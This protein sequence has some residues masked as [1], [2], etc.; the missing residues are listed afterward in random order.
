MSTPLAV[1]HRPAEKFE[2][3]NPRATVTLNAL[4]VGLEALGFRV[5]HVVQPTVEECDLA[6]MFGVYKSRFP[7]TYCRQQIIDGQRLSGGD[8]LI[9][10]RGWIHRDDHYSLGFDDIGGRGRYADPPMLRDAQRGILYAAPRGNGL[11]WIA[12]R[13][14]DIRVTGSHLVIG[15][16]P[17]DTSCQHADLQ[18][19]LDSSVD[20]LKSR[21]VDDV[22]FRPHPLAVGAL[23]PPAG[24]RVSTGTLDDDLADAYIV[25]TFNS[26]TGVDALLAGVPAL[27]HDEGSMIWGAV[28][29]MSNCLD[30]EVS[31]I[32]HEWERSI[33]WKQWTPAEMASGYALMH[34]LPATRSR[35]VGMHSLRFSG[36]VEYPDGW[37]RPSGVRTSSGR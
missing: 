30:S 29:Q 19:W 8:T 37:T 28:R 32:V 22:V 11:D 7:E 17:W 13:E 25:V 18:E 26:T 33:L 31:R 16:V 6:V 9:V 27:A 15:Q 24:A 10:E 36:R 12:P 3:G 20:A 23:R 21:G 5:R 2:R 34:T 4:G 14:I 35:A 1:I